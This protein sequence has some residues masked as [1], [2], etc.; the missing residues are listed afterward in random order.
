MVSA[1]RAAAL[2]AAYAVSERSLNE[3]K[4]KVLEKVG[5]NKEKA[6]RD[7]I[8]QDFVNEHP[9]S[10]EVIILAGGDV[11][12]L[13]RMTGRYF[14]STVEN[15][16]KAENAVNQELFNHQYAS[17]SHF[18]DEIGLAPTSFSDDVGWNMAQ[19]GVLEL[20]FSTVM[21]ENDQ[22]CIAV[23]FTN[24]PKTEYTQLY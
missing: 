12:M 6:I 22:P 24:M 19:T 21:A 16:K 15:L 18:Y 5:I 4:D 8:A 3:Y 1:K 20:Q 13:D 11:L 10:K 14:R 9:P 2:A 23:D 7:D 17:L